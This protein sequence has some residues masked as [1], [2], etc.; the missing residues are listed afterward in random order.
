L[1]GLEKKQHCVSEK[2]ESRAE[3][4]AFPVAFSTGG[5]KVFSLISVDAVLVTYTVKKIGGNI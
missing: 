4:D 5:M 1:G 2:S 3:K